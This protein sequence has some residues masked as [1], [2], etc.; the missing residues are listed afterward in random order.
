MAWAAGFT[1][2]P[3]ADRVSTEKYSYERSRSGGCVSGKCASSQNAVTGRFSVEGRART[4]YIS[5]NVDWARPVVVLRLASVVRSTAGCD[6]QQL[7]SARAIKG[8]CRRIDR[9]LHSK[10]ANRVIS[11]SPPAHVTWPLD[12]ATSRTSR[13]SPGW[14][15]RVSPSLALTHIT[16]RRTLTNRRDDGA[17]K[18]LLSRSCAPQLGSNAACRILVAVLN[19]DCATGC[20]GGAVAILVNDTTIQPLLGN[21]FLRLRTR[22][23]GYGISQ[24]AAV[25]DFDL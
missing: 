23:S 14:N 11:D 5:S 19:S 15:L 4:T 12:G 8:I 6:L 21:E 13:I 24:S 22:R 2:N 7:N 16:P 18:T 20:A 1:I 17:W 9:L 25:I 3:S 10:F